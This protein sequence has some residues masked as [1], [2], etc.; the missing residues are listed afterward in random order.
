MRPARY[1]L[2]AVLMTAMAAPAA[3]SVS[4]EITHSAENQGA[5]FSDVAV[6]GINTLYTVG[7]KPVGLF[8]EENAWFSSDGGATYQVKQ[9]SSFSGLCSF[10]AMFN[11]YNSTDFLNL[12][13][14]AIAGGSV[15]PWCQLLPSPECLACVLLCEP[16][17]WLTS[18]GGGSLARKYGRGDF[19]GEFF[20][21]DYLTN[22]HLIAG[23]NGGTMV[24]CYSTDCQYWATINGPL[25]LSGNYTDS[26]FYD[27]EFGAIA[28]TVVDDDKLSS[29]MPESAD[30]AFE[31]FTALRD[32]SRYLKDPVYRLRLRAQGKAPA[33][34]ASMGGCYLTE[35]GRTW[36]T[37]FEED[38]VAALLTSFYNELRGFVITDEP[39][40]ATGAQFTLNYTK[41][42]GNNWY[43]GELPEQGVD[44][45]PYDAA[46]VKFLSSR[47]GYIAGASLGDDVEQ[48]FVLH[49]NDGGETW[50]FMLMQPPAP[51]RSM[52]FFNRL[53][54]YIVGDKNFTARYVGVNEAPSADAGADQTV[55][56]DARVVLDGGASDDP[57]DYIDS[58]IWIQTLGDD[59]EL[60]EYQ[61]PQPYFI[62]H[63][64]G[65]Y[66][67][68]LTI[69]AG[70]QTDSDVVRITVSDDIDDDADDDADDDDDDDFWDDDVDDDANDDIDDD[71][72]DGDDDDG[73]PYSGDNEND[74]YSYESIDEGDEDGCCGC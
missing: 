34:T 63:E 46:D 12:F 44:G 48:G 14:G 2:L 29:A 73:S 59:V 10:P 16:T 70:G 67:F 57:D 20:F 65:V 51:L 47:L 27:G 58:W 7:A 35:G 17:V 30:E 49:T 19:F 21:V 39:D 31:R 28:A 62:P 41:D 36:V 18:D 69:E 55:G 74:E 22:D 6:M 24:E 5:L 56:I 61:S 25:G 1:I 68:K 40:S 8:G 42:G 33:I 23:G 60:W 52:D 45:N 50:S 71:N 13:Q 54:G 4:W 66:K 9:S 37:V 3:A 11:T 15:P 43:K 32:A 53:L 64:A 72:D 26:D 38:D